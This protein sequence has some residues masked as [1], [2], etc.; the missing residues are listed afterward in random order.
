MSEWFSLTKISSANGNL[1]L[2]SLHETFF[3]RVILFARHF[4]EAI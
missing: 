1:A 2:V 3:S 4:F